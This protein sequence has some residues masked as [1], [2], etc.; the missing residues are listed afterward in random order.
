MMENLF[1]RLSELISNMDLPKRDWTQ[2]TNFRWLCRN[3]YMRNA[4]N[5]HFKDAIATMRQI[6]DQHKF[7]QIRMIVGE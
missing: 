1:G 4:Q 3:L 2:A 7:L 5:K 6:A